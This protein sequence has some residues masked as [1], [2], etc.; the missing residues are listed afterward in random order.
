M[1]GAEALSNAARDAEHAARE[2]DLAG[3]R[4]AVAPV[5][6]LLESVVADLR[7]RQARGYVGIAA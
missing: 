6:R 2:G 7:T 5:E 1:F 3:L 4:T